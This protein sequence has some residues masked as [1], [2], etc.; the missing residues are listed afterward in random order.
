MPDF[1]ISQSPGDKRPS[2][3][4]DGRSGF[5]LTEV[6]VGL[7]ILTIVFTSL[8]SFARGN[9]KSMKLS[10]NL[11]Q[12]DYVATTITE[13]E[14]TWFADTVMKYSGKIRF[15]SL[16]SSLA[17]G[18]HDTI[19]ASPAVRNGTSYYWSFNFSRIGNVADSLV[20]GKGR[21]VWDSLTTNKH[22]FTWGIVL[23]KPVR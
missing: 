23:G 6:L 2:S 22:T 14:K 12:S 20:L 16:Y 19:N 11:V 8:A 1:S 21:L 3:K 4:G 13:G 17:S 15:D 18:S 9:R 10:N 5:S 7:V